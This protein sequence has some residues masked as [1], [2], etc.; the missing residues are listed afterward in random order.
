MRGGQMRTYF[1]GYLQSS[2]TRVIACLNADGLLRMT[3]RSSALKD[4][5]KE[6]FKDFNLAYEELYMTQTTWKVVEP[7]LREKLKITILKNLVP[8]YRLY[9][10]R[11]GGQLK[12]LK[13]F[14]EY[15]KYS[16]EDLEKQI[17][18]LFE[19]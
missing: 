5:L 11:Y 10:V 14:T 7:Q 16:P 3:G 18:D 9:V 1:S 15:L 2:W 8:A 19:G 6:R 4:A 17:L 13:N 12:E